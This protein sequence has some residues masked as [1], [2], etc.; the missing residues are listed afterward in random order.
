MMKCY[1]LIETHYEDEWSYEPE[2]GETC[3]SVK[4]V[5]VLGAYLGLAGAELAKGKYKT[6]K[7][8]DMDIVMVDLGADARR[9]ETF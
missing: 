3:E 6:P 5:S 4:K 8:T 2:E 7:N 1:L 9:V